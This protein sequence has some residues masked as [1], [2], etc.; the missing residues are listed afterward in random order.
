M[1]LE[2]RHRFGVL[3]LVAVG[4]LALMQPWIS[5]KRY[6]AREL[7]SAPQIVVASSH[8]GG[9]GSL[10]EGIF[11]AARGDRAARIVLRTKRVVLTTPLPPLV[12]RKG[13]VIDARESGCEIDG[14]RLSGGPVLE[15]RAPNSLV[16]GLR[17]R[18]AAGSGIL[19]RAAGVHLRNLRI[20]DSAEAV[21]LSEGASDV[22]VENS[23]FE[24]NGIG[25]SLSNG[26]PRVSIH[27]NSFRRHDRAAVWAV[28]AEAPLHAGSAGLIVRRN[29]FEEDRISVVQIH[30]PGR[31][32]ENDFRGAQ[33]AAVYLMGSG[34][35]VRDNRGREGA[36]LG[37]FADG[38]EE[39]LIEGNELDHNAAVGILLRS[40]RSS[41]VQRNRIYNNGYGIAVVF[42]EAIRPNL[43][44]DNLLLS[45][46]QDGLYI[47][48]GSPVLRGNRALQ[49]RQAGLRILN[50]VPRKGPVIAA[51]PLLSDNVLLGNLLDLPV[52]GEYRIPPE[53][54]PEV[55]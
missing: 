31:V 53:D 51:R 40:G 20:T 46:L 15:L 24:S 23:R 42:G 13:I 35:V 36:S 25:I 4:V 39:A 43:V 55:R 10:R 8:D 30:V 22:V 19:V 21:T 16:D 2:R 50:F 49:S 27:D 44:V 5:G 26:T 11:A 7:W 18:R 1:R 52:R 12:N 41:V 54:E 29:H 9:H 6:T 47:V 14:E 17:I 48:G 37:I 45:Q 33:E 3:A 32:E 34:I 38:G 28:S